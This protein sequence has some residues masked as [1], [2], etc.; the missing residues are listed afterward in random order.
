MS[1]VRALGHFTIYTRGYTGIGHY[2]TYTSDFFRSSHTFFAVPILFSQYHYLFR[3]SFANT[4]FFSRKIMIFDC[5][6]NS[7]RYL[8]EIFVKIRH[9]SISYHDLLQIFNELVWEWN[10]VK[11]RLF[12]EFLMKKGKSVNSFVLLSSF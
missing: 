12:F 4:L 6:I 11:T 1:L 2:T 10:Y 8:Y 5:A 7:S 9:V 3:K